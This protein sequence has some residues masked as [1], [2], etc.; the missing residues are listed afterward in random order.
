MTV[1]NCQWWTHL[2]VPSTHLH[3]IRRLRPRPCRRSVHR[4]LSL[5]KRRQHVMRDINNSLTVQKERVVRLSVFYQPLHGAQD[6][7]LRRKPSRIL[8]IVCQDNNIF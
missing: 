1:A 7:G 2:M 4:D 8:S 5:K 3:R 6:V